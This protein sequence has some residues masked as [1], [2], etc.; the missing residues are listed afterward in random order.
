MDRAAPLD[1][2]G[3]AIRRFFFDSKALMYM[4][5]PNLFAV[6]FRLL[7]GDW[8]HKEGVLPQVMKLAIFVIVPHVPVCKIIDVPPIVIWL[9][10]NCRPVEIDDIQ[11]HEVFVVWVFDKLQVLA[12][13]IA[14]N[15]I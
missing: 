9:M 1:P 7:V 14:V 6:V 10:T 11:S 8:A 2:I 12:L 13:H 15:D 4:A 5:T 3:S